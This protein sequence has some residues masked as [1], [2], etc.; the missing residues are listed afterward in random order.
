[1][2]IFDIKK[3]AKK[4][5]AE[6]SRK[7]A[8]SFSDTHGFVI[9]MI[10]QAIQ[11]DLPN[12]PLRK[13]RGTDTILTISAFEIDGKFMAFQFRFKAGAPTPSECALI[14]VKE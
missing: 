4:A 8:I 6:Q 1:M 14:E 10:E 13:L 2:N 5:A 12:K 3:D 11:R 9:N 7:A